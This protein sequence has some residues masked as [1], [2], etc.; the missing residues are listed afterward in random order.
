MD[1]VALRPVT[2]ADLPIFYEQQR[3][4]EAHRMAAFTGRDPEDR[5]G[6]D[7][8][9]RRLRADRSIVLRTIVADGEVA[10]YAGKYVRDGQPEVTYWL[11]REFWGR[12]I[13]TRALKLFLNEV[14]E[15]PIYAGAAHDNFGSLRVLEKCGFRRI[16]VERG[17]AYA[18]REEVEEVRLVLE[19]E[20]GAGAAPR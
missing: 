3:D 9:W 17:Y 20:A 14:T 13:A 5:P 1:T 6:F 11:G 8:H 10:G 16:G 7:G 4:P 19:A 15:R 12:G 18:R 2:F